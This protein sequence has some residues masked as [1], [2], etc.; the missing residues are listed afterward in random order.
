MSRDID[1]EHDVDCYDDDDDD[2][3]DNDEDDDDEDDG[4]DDGDDGD[5]EEDDDDDIVVLHGSVP[6]RPGWVSNGQIQ[7]RPMQITREKV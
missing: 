1:N 6:S 4:E 2:D 3:D 7:A 5:D